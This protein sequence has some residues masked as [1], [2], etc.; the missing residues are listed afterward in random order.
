[1]STRN[2]LK[3]NLEETLEAIRSPKF[4]NQKSSSSFLGIVD[5][6][7]SFGN[8]FS[9]IFH[10]IENGLIIFWEDSFIPAWEWIN[11]DKWYQILTK[12]LVLGGI[13]IL[14]GAFFAPVTAT[15]IVVGLIVATITFL[16][17][18]FSQGWNE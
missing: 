1:M 15:T 14:I 2:R 16:W 13:S 4:Y 6:D 5:F 18:I 8:P 10:E 17:E 7:L 3:M 12:T 11:G 9:F